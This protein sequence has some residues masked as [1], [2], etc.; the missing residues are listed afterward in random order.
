MNC[1]IK[2]LHEFLFLDGL[3]RAAKF[4]FTI[5]VFLHLKISILAKKKNQYFHRNLKYDGAKG[6]LVFSTCKG[7]ISLHLKQIYLSSKNKTKQQKQQNKH[8]FA[9]KNVHAYFTHKNGQNTF[10]PN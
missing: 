9:G 10:N 7:S 4:Y 2:D 5:S 1:F 8:I 6:L 3:C